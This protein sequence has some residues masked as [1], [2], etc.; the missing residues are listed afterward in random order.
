MPLQS[1]I[2]SLLFI[3]GE[4]ISRE[5]LSRIT[6]ATPDDV[7]SAIAAI[8]DDF[9]T[10]GIVL[11]EKDGDCQFGTHPDNAAAVS[12]LL[13]SELDG[14]LTRA[15]I[16]TASIIAYKGP[17]TRASI[18][19]IRGVNSAIALRNLHL[20]G[21]IKRAPNPEDGRAPL[22]QVTIDFLKHLGLTRIE[23]LPSYDEFRLR[24]GDDA[25][26]PQIANDAAVTD[27]PVQTV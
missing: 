17:L 22:Y 11:V 2:E 6:G 5:Q 9:R 1:I 12:A 19:N 26:H 24:A 3:H 13:K 10:R 4:P 16:E 23:D 7:D 25:A 21:L 15:S 14:P 18:E 27:S 20:R 8:R